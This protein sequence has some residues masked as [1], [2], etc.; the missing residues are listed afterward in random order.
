MLGLIIIEL[1]VN[2]ALAERSQSRFLGL[3][4]SVNDGY[5]SRKRALL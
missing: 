2:T 4:W 5:L 3:R 1:D